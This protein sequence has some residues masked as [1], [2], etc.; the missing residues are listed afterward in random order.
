M[1]LKTW[2]MDGEEQRSTHPTR[3]T[4]ERAIA[5]LDWRSDDLCGVT[6]QH[7]AQ[8]WAD[9]SG[10]LRADVGGLSL[11]L[12]DDGIQHVSVNAPTNLDQIIE[13]LDAYL[14]GDIPRVYELLYGRP[15]TADELAVRRR[16]E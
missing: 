12:E 2:D 7:D 4:I 6:L 14:R 16:T 15:F 1:I 5:E 13:F 11:M 3:E 10:N 9:G 8:N